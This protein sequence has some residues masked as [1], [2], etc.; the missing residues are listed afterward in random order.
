M[1]TERLWRAAAIT[2]CAAVP[3]SFYVIGDLTDAFP[4]VLTV[5]SEETGPATGPRAQAEDYDRV[6]PEA[7]GP[8]VAASVPTE[9][10]RDLQARMDAHA[11]LPVV[12]GN[13]SYAVV[14]RQR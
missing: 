8:P 11:S 7:P 13:L 6:T 10:A 4:G 14:D 5:V 3:A 2:L 1:P 12:A 9:Q